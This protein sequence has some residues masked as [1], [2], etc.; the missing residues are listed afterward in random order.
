LVDLHIGLGEYGDAETILNAEEAKDA[1][2]C[3]RNVSRGLEIRYV[4]AVE[5]R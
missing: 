1:Y 5:N 4:G 3:R 2:A